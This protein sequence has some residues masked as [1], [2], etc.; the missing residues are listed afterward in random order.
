VALKLR[1]ALLGAGNI[2][3]DGHGPQWARDEHLRG[4][5]EIVA[6]ADL[7]PSNLRSARDLF[8]GATAYSR[9]QDLLAREDLDF[10]DICTPPFTH[11][12]L[13]EQAAERGLHVLCEKPLAPSL[14]DAQG[15]AEAVCAARIVFQPCH[16]YH[17]SPDWQVVRRLI[18]RLGRI[19]F[20][21]YDVQRTHANPGNPHWSPDWR[22]DPDRAG[23]GILV[24]HGAHI[25]YQ[26][27]SILGEPKTVQATVS[28]LLHRSYGVEDTALVILDFGECLAQVNLT[29]ASWRRQIHFRF[30]GEHGEL[31]GDD[32][33]VQIVADVREHVD[34]GGGLSQGSSHSDWYSPLF[35]RFAERVRADDHSSENL[36]EAVYVTRLI[37]RAYESARTGRTLPLA[38]PTPAAAL[39]LAEDPGPVL[40]ARLTEGTEQLTR[41]GRGR[42]ARFLRWSSAAALLAAGVWAF[43]DVAWAPLWGALATAKPGWIAVAALVN[44]GA[45]ALQ[46]VRWLALLR[47]LTRLATFGSAFKSLMIGFAFSTVLPARAGELARMQSLSR[48]TGLPQASVLGSIVLDHL[49]NGAGLLLGLALLP[50]FFD[51]PLWIRSGAFATAA[52]FTAVGTLVFV[53]RNTS[54]HSVARGRFL[55][56]KLAGFLAMAREGL[57][58]TRRPRALSLSATASL[59]SWTLEL[60]VTAIAM[61]AVGLQLPFSAVVLVLLA[62]NLALAVPLAPPGN[63][64]TIEVGAILALLGFGVAKEQALA[65]AI[66]Y[67]LLQVVPIGILGILFASR[68][69]VDAPA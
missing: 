6:V 45:V 50:F 62:V 12:A 36:E 35:R 19:H 52:L 25:F 5:V 16:Q 58:A 38:E 9:A 32:R 55:P 40:G 47:P 59:G 11:R 4:E 3:L 43:H 41:A 63:I 39:A 26:L 8:P 13:I 29:W 14:A 46:A 30:V 15:I 44:L 37:T 68:R 24:D 27:R 42:Q 34:F 18:P 54:T 31:L 49:V 33:G 23:G 10:C 67:H 2:A 21:E 66:V 22:T 56:V 60:G 20:A 69:L 65:F 1:G 51:V 48:R 53:L 61:R 28:T 64:G 7:C 17:Y 57:G